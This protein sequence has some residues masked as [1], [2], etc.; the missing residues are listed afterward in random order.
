MKSKNL[1]SLSVS[2]AFLV[3][4]V[5]GLLIYFGQGSHTVD[6]VHAW[7]GILFF[8]AAVFHIVNNWSSIKGYSKD[9]R[10]GGIRRELILP[11]L[12]AIVFAGGIAADV[13]VF[14]DLAN[15]GKKLF[16]GDKPK[17]GGPLSQAAVDSIAYSVE[18]RYSEALAKLDTAVLNRSFTEHATI[19]TE[20]GTFLSGS[21]S[22]KK[23][24]EAEKLTTKIDHATALDD[25][26]IVVHGTA[27]SS[28]ATGSPNTFSYTRVLKHEG[29]RWLIA[30]VQMGRVAAKGT[31]V[32]S[33]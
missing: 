5:T 1:V 7:F 30:A 6:H 31:A 29:D 20:A 13:P 33:R 11:S 2:A 10:T 15:A 14:K 16:R 17:K 19:S 12:L 4:S 27:T 21:E 18:T 28:P 23:A 25:N 9:R 32:A 22:I 26:V 3:L 8:G 24:G